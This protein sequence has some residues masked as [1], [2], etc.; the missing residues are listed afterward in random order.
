VSG[1]P[2]G[3]LTKR[4]P[5]SGKLLT[6]LLGAGAAGT[7]FLRKRRARAGDEP[8]EPRGPTG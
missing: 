8:L 1:G 7:A 4:L 6:G 5:I 2:L 3:A